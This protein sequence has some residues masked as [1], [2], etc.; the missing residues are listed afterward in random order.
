MDA[1][2]DPTQVIEKSSKKKKKSKF[3]QALSKSKP[4]FDPGKILIS[5]ELLDYIFNIYLM[6]LTSSSVDF[7]ME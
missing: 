2:Y 3:K 6:P 1:D 4:V 5:I 7:E